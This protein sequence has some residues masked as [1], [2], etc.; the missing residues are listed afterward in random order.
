MDKPQTEKKTIYGIDFDGTIVEEAF[1]E[2]GKPIEKTVKFIKALKARGDHW[3]LITMREGKVLREAVKFLYDIG[4]PPD[5][6]NDNLPERKEK[7]GNNPR[8]IYADI[9]ID[10][11]NAGGL[12]LPEFCD[13]PLI[14]KI[15]TALNTLYNRRENTK[16]SEKE[17]SALKK[18][19]A[20][21][22]AEQELE[23]I[24]SLYSSSYMFKRSA[25]V[26]LLNNWTTEYDR[27]IN[28]NLH[29]NKDKRYYAN[30]KNIGRKPEH[31]VR[32]DDF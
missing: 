18:I 16:W 1:P 5:M 15:K 10:D 7:W 19:A 8:K 27:A 12:F 21:P 22:D 23:A 9:Y 26:T 2:I 24:I 6:V 28:P 17:I 11:H 32:S 25:I 20:R 30:G 4:I 13:N 3:I 31:F 14:L 29:N